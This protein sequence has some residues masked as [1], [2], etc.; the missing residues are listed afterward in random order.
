MEYTL[1]FA[2]NL[3]Q[4]RWDSTIYYRRSGQADLRACCNKAL[5]V[6]ARPH[7]VYILYACS[8]PCSADNPIPHPV[9]LTPKD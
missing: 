4:P 1:D 8:L 3:T 2:V 9:P 6:V 5:C 7:R